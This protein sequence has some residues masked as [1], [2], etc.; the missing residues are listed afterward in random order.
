MPVTRGRY[1]A[2]YATHWQEGSFHN[3]FLFD[4]YNRALA[5]VTP[6]F[7]NILQNPGG[8]NTTEHSWG[9]AFPITVLDPDLAPDNSGVVMV[10]EPKVELYPN[11][12]DGVTTVSSA[13]PLRMVEAYD[14]AGRLLLR[15]P[16]TG[17]TVKIDMSGYLPGC[18]ILKIHTSAGTAHRKLILR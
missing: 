9:G 6:G 15:Q 3:G 13:V 7:K 10:T 1:N 2:T 8:V 16:A 4:R 17:R 11:P 5:P 14:V 12:T 18:Y